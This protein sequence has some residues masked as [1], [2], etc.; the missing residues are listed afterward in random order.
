MRWELCSPPSMQVLHFF[1]AELAHGA[2]LCVKLWRFAGAGA[3]LCWVCHLCVPVCS[4]LAY[5]TLPTI[6]KAKIASS[7]FERNLHSW[8]PP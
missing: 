8:K 7:H 1:A 4:L 3:L 2:T 5:L 6:C